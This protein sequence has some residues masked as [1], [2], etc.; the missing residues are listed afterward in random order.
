MHQSSS[1]L[2]FLHNFRLIWN[3]E[4]T[5]N[6]ASV[7]SNQDIAN[8]IQDPTV[9]NSHLG[10]CISA[11]YPKAV[12]RGKGSGTAYHGLKWR[13]WN[14]ELP[15]NSAKKFVY[16]EYVTVVEETSDELMLLRPTTAVINGDVLNIEIRMK[17]S[18]S[19]ELKCMNRW[20]TCNRYRLAQV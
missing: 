15:F 16:P 6:T 10:K 14:N 13:D 17:K 12:P 5:S 11:L 19:L 9:N 1:Q 4:Y 8:A 18:G 3:I 20:G 2:F 7:I